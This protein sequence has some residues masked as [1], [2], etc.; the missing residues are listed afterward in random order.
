MKR[1]GR[2]AAKLWLRVFKPFGWRIV[3]TTHILRSSSVIRLALAHRH[4]HN[5]GPSFISKAAQRHDAAKI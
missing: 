5:I 2:D 4:P 3:G 1:E